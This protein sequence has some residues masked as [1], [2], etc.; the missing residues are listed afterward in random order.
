MHEA[1]LC[2]PNQNVPSS[3]V[4]LRLCAMVKRKYASSIERKRGCRLSLLPLY[5]HL[6]CNVSVFQ[7]LHFVA[8]PTVVLDREGILALVMTGS[9]GLAGFH[10]AHGGLQ[11]ASFKWEYLGVA[12]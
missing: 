8:L 5:K 2:E 7:H 1:V 4:G 11:G 3:L 6:E 12:L 9:A 10:V